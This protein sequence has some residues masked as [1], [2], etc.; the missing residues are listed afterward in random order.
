MT[1]RVVDDLYA[2]RRSRWRRYGRL[3]VRGLFLIA[4]VVLAAVAIH[5]QY[6][7][8]RRGLSEISLLSLAG[9]LVCLEVGLVLS[10]LSWRTILSDLGSHLPLR[11]SARVFFVGQLGKYLPGSVWPVLAQME[12]AH[13]H[14][15]PRQRTLT[16]S[17]VAIGIGVVGALLVAGVLLP[18]AVHGTAWRLG[19][20]TALVIGLVAATPPVLNRLVGLG[21]RLLRREPL[22]DPLSARGL[23]R[24]TMLASGSWTFQGLGVFVLA[25]PLGDS[26]GRLL[27]ISI[28]GYA[29]A[30][31]AGILLIV[32]PAGLGVR[33]PV[34]IAALAA[35]LAAGAALVVALIVRLLASI[36]DLGTGSVFALLPTSRAQLQ[37]AHRATAQPAPE[38]HDLNQ[39]Q[40]TERR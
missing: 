39:R 26:P 13:D 21:L 12:L 38:H 11:A 33:E 9:A 23:A 28:G 6:A 24:A 20:L 4:V 36:V 1:E 10:M 3:S 18:V 37:E 8:V 35:Q 5:D 19:L 29:A 15:V 7:A 40:E 2:G 31:A 14:K 34:L 27:L 25:A 17:L 22:Q 32:A 30:S 16:A